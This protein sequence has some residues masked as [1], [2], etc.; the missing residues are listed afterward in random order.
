[1]RLVAAVIAT[2]ISFIYLTAQVSG[3][4][5]IMSRF[6]GVNFII[7]V[8]LGLSAVLFCSYLGG[9]KAISWTQVT[10]GVVLI[11]ACLLYT[12]RCV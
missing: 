6:F 3:V 8:G 11:V 10:Q 7:G 4:G 2:I 1:M 5:I 9:M 12:S